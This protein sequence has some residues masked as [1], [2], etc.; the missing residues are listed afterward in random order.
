M[1]GLCDPSNLLFEYSFYPPRTDTLFSNYFE[2]L[3]HIS[4]PVS[5]ELMISAVVSGGMNVSAAVVVVVVV[6]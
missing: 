4:A 2:D 1:L 3:F 5:S 6:R